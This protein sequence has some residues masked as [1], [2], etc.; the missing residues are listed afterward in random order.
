[1]SLKKAP[2]NKTGIKN[3][4][5]ICSINDIEVDNYGLFDLKWFN[6][7]MKLPD[8]IKTIKIDEMVNIKYWRGKKL[9]NKNFKYGSCDFEI[10]YMY[11]L[12]ENKKVEYEIFGGMIIMELTNNHLD[13][14]TEEL[15][16]DF[17]GT[18]SLNKRIN[19]L[20]LYLDSTKKIDKKLI[21]THVFANSYLQNQKTLFEFDIISKVNGKKNNYN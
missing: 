4:D 3:G 1:M 6:E 13:V 8:L 14:I 11:P 10:D 20:L 2:I 9:Y 12:F 21:I 7:K 19:N 16:E 15:F 18:S 5:I 17:N